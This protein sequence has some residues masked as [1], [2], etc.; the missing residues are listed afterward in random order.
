MLLVIFLLRERAKEPIG[1]R[2]SWEQEK[3]LSYPTVSN[4]NWL[5]MGFWR[6]HQTLHTGLLETNLK[7]VDILNVN[8]VIFCRFFKP[9]YIVITFLSKTS[10]KLSTTDI[11]LYFFIILKVYANAIYKCLY[12]KKLNNLLQG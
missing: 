4:F 8:R 3:L 9:I 2:H 10:V 6:W 11:K 7:T 1:I 12:N 5:A